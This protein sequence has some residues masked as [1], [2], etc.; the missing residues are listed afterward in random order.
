MGRESPGPRGGNRARV[1]LDPS[2]DPGARPLR[3]AAA[4]VLVSQAPGYLL[5]V[6]PDDIDA[7]CFERLVADANALT[8]S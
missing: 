6:E 4:T 3:G 7:V 1:H 5:R 2:A 8:A